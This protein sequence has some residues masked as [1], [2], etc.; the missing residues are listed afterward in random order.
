MAI[1]I[2]ELE[3][4]RSLSGP[5]QFV[6]NYQV[7]GTLVIDDVAN[8]LF[9]SSPTNYGFWLRMWDQKR[10]APL[11][12]GV[13]DCEVPYG[14]GDIPLLGISSLP[15]GSGTGGSGGSTPGSATTPADGDPLGREWSTDFS[16]GSFIRTKSIETLGGYSLIFDT[17]SGTDV[18][19]VITPN[20]S[21]DVIG[22]NPETG[23][24]AGVDVGSGV[25]RLEYQVK[26]PVLTMGYIKMLR[27]LMS[28]E[29]HVNS[30]AFLG[31]AAG[32]VK[33]VGTNINW[34]NANGFTIRFQFDIATNRTGIKVSD[35]LPTVDVKG[36]YYLDV[37]YMTKPNPDDPTRSLI[38]VPVQYVVHRVFPEA[39]LN[40]IFS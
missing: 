9:T 24:V 7:R 4:S 28:P 16:L 14:V 6:W 25:Q 8:I 13:W 32:E 33:I 5:N 2:T 37:T 1:E 3:K 27:R 23:D 31:Q 15:P 10:I 40:I 12:G 26:V 17:G 38:K 30:E 29:P 20:A 11:G 34:S 35:D 19:I 36:W 39:D 18:P 21:G 22:Y